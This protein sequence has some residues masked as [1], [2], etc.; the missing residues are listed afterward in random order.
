MK[1]AIC[2]SRIDFTFLGKIDGTIA[3]DS[4]GKKKSV[5]SNCQKDG[6]IRELSENLRDLSQ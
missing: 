3:R 4:K 2:N 1:C 5:C 6:R